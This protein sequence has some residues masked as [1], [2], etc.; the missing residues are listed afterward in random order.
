[1]QFIHLSD[2]HLGYRQYNLDERENDIYESFMECIDKIIEI[3]PDFVIH[4]GDLFE[5]PQPS[6]NALRT[7]IEGFL[8]LKEKNIPIYL[9]HGNHDIPKSQQKGRPFGILKKIVGSSLKTFLRE[10]SHVFKDS[11]FIGGIEYAPQNK[12]QKSHEDIQKIILDSKNYHKKILLFHQSVTPF[13]PQSFELQI[14]DFPTDFNYFAGGHIHQRALKPVNDGNSVFSYAGSTEIMSVSEVSNY[15]KHK[16]GFYL[17]DLSRDFDIN[18]VEKIDTECRNFLT[19]KKIE[20]EKDLKELILELK[21]FE[22]NLKKPILYCNVSENIFNTSLEELKSL[23]LYSRFNKIDEEGFES[24][25]FNENN[26]EEVFQEY[27]KQKEMP[28]DFVYQLYKKLLESE[29]E[30]IEYTDNYFN[31][32]Y[33]GQ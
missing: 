19:D 32:H 18:S 25:S 14:T 4:S 21:S 13:M 2:S 24:I 22:N 17:G 12:I 8:K 26:I 29:K 31:N 28:V 10:K 16:K 1:M 15:K 9:I 3:K 20:N 6:V 23:V 30:C 11:V 33:R 27:V 7:A 5:S